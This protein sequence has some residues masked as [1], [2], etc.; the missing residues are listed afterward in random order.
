M[1]KA[2]THKLCV[3]VMA[4][5]TLPPN[6]TLPSP[7][8]FV[9]F[10]LWVILIGIST[11][12]FYLQT[13]QEYVAIATGLAGNLQVFL[14]VSNLESLV[15]PFPQDSLHPVFVLLQYAKTEKFLR[16]EK[17]CSGC[18]LLCEH[19][20][21]WT[22]TGLWILWGRSIPQVCI[23]SQSS[24]LLIGCVLMIASIHMTNL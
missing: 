18:F 14:F 11:L 4:A 8:L 13:I 15:L 19:G 9:L 21:P 22:K 20:T 3:N 16:A 1:H 6:S 2:V 5:F 7:N 24:N 17:M 23:H 10:P 12:H